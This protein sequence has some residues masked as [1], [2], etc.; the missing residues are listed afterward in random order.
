MRR[1]GSL[2]LFTSAKF[3]Y[4]NSYRKVSRKKKKKTPNKKNYN[5]KEK[6]FIFF[7]KQMRKEFSST[8]GF[9]YS[10]ERNYYYFLKIHLIIYR[11]V[12]YRAD[13]YVF[14]TARESEASL[15]QW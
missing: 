12:F 6:L 13:F 14:L 5:A 1:A 9:I 3:I 4:L 2:F 10:L 7:F 11:S 15:A 8:N